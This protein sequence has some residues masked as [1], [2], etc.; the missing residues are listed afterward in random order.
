M[1]TPTKTID[2]FNKITEME[3]RDKHE[4]QETTSTSNT[5]T[6]RITTTTINTTS[7]A[8]VRPV[9]NYVDE[10]NSIGVINWFKNKHS[11]AIKVYTYTEDAY[12]I[13]ILD[14]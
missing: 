5:L 4:R 11:F 7:E 8:S 9:M 6:H 3:I 10:T 2:D 1:I 13:N 12:L 14:N